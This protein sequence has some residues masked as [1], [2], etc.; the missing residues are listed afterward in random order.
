MEHERVVLANGPAAALG[1][2]YGMRR[3]GVQALSADV[4]QI[5]RD[6]AAE[7]R[8]LTSVALTL[9]HFTPAVT[10]DPEP[11]SATVML[12]VTAS[13]R[14]FGGHRALCRAIRARVRQLGTFAQIGS[15]TTAQ[16][17]AWLARQ[18]LRKT[19]RGIVRPARR[20]VQAARMT[21]L[22]DRLPVEC[23][24][25]GRSRMARRHRLPHAGPGAAAARGLVAPH[26]HGP[27]GAA[28]SGL[29]QGAQRLCVVRGAAH[30]C[31]A[32]GLPGRI[33]S[34]DGVLAGAQRLLLALSGW[35]A[36]QQAGVTRC[37]LMLEH[38]RYRLGEEIDST[39]VHLGLAQPSRDPV[40]LSKLLRE[41]LDK[42]P[43][44]CAGGWP[45]AARGSDGNLRAAKRFA[46]SGTGAEP[47]ELGR[48]IDTLVARL[49]RDNVLQPHPLADIVPNAPTS[50]A[51]WTRRPRAARR[52]SVAARASALA[53]R[54]ALALRVQHHR[55][56]HDGPLVML[57]RPSVSKPA[58][59]MVRW[60]RA[61]TSLPN[62]PTACAA[63]S[64]ASARAGPRAMGRKTAANTAGSCTACL[65]ER[66][67]MLP[68][69]SSLLP[70]LPDYV[71]LHCIS[72]FT[73]L[74]GA[75]HPQELIARA[76]Q[77]GYSGLALTD[78]CSVAG[79]ARAHHAIK[80]LREECGSRRAQRAASGGRAGGGES[81]EVD[82]WQ[83][84]TRRG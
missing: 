46:V 2:R 71:E 27:A 64:I 37:V 34:A 16:G 79:T 6:A 69:L 20:A 5:E 41:K 60:P 47:A 39:A 35:L 13:L 4:V 11:E 77:L 38:E 18:P 29:W 7:A 28:G 8:W 15:G 19:S 65:P 32:H 74:D 73:F 44:P 54:S 56:V 22:L 82:A 57:T 66:V 78:E 26:R 31:A 75:S 42:V 81:D 10:I 33:E 84:S 61:I 68:A 51:R 40:H 1:V 83:P 25:A 52:R 43:L 36:A 24:H 9:L 49:G 45:G 50:G 59:G 55:P 21:R 67:A 70:S 76:F 12:D 63:G 30:V 80:T 62:A 48:L 58:G 23:L 14:L 72:N 53:A 3:G 17:A